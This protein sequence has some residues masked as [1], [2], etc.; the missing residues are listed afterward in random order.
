MSRPVIF[1]FDLL[2]I[3]LLTL[4]IYFPRY[5][6][7]DM[8]VAYVALNV[9]IMAIGVA[10]TVNTSIG[11]GFGLGL[12]GTLSIIRL[13]SSELAHQ[14]IAYYFAALALGLLGGIELKPTYLSFILPAI[15]VAVMFVFDHPRLFGTHRRQ[16]VI[17]DRAYSDEAELNAALGALLNADIQHVELL[18]L[19]FVNDT[20]SVDVR[21][22]LQRPHP[23]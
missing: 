8:V 6:R 21:Y 20:T 10:L 12:F 23:A 22:R 9:G 5:H 19:D 15:V 14:E 4:A 13:R 17:L 11:T 16:N 1:A 3:G 7:R 18:R 2:A